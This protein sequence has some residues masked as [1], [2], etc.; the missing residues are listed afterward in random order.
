MHSLL[1]AYH[2]CLKLKINLKFLS[3]LKLNLVYLRL[4]DKIASYI[5]TER[6]YYS[7]CKVKFIFFHLRLFWDPKT[8]SRLME[9]LN[10]LVL[11][12]NNL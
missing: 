4:Q 5:F 9:K 2:Q 11:K 10:F 12:Y 3:F 1:E 6:L 8:L 7:T